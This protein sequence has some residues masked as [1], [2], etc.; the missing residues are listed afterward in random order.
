[1]T[2]DSEMNDKQLEGLK[3]WKSK[4]RAVDWEIC[5]R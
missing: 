5:G 2:K 1:M 3:V 4:I